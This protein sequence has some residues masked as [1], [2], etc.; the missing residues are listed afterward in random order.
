MNPTF[1]N[2]MFD[3]MKPD[4]DRLM[5]NYFK[6]RLA[7]ILPEEMT[8]ETTKMSDLI[9]QTLV[10]NSWNSCLAEIKKRAGI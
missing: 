7:E 10:M 3:D 8:R 5:E 6:E 9:Q 4:M 2:K 1:W